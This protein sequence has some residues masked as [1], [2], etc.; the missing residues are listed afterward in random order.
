MHNPKVLLLD[1]P[2]TGLDPESRKNLWEYLQTIRHTEKITIFLTTHYLE[3]ADYVCI[4]NKGKIAAKGTPEE[5]KEILTERYIIA[6]TNKRKKLEKELKEK[7]INYI[8]SEVF[9]IFLNR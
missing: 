2:T 4:I 1:E 3:E 7:K 8:K 5:L 9:H 6:N